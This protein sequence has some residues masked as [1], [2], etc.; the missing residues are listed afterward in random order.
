MAGLWAARA[1]IA[2]D[3]VRAR[4]LRRVFALPGTRLG[5]PRVG[6]RLHL[7]W[8][9]WWQAHLLD[10]LVDA[11]LREPEAE[12]DKVIAALVRGIHVRNFGAWTNRYYDDIAW[13]GLALQRA[14]GSERAL[15]AIEARLRSGWT[16]D[17]GGGIWWR[18]GDTFKNVPANGPAAI[19][20]A[21][22]GDHAWARTALDWM[23]RTLVDPETGLL[24]DGVRVG[25]EV[26][27]TIYTYCQG[28]FIGAAV[29][30]ST[31]DLAART[32][33]AVRRHV[34]TAHVLPGQGTGDGGLF[35]GI[36]ARYLAQSALRLP[37]AE[38][39]TARRLVFASADALWRHRVITADGP[40]FGTDWTTRSGQQRD[41]S[42]QLSA[43]MTL[44]AAALLARAGGASPNGV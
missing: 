37:T 21:R 16:D 7:R 29:E 13:L 19:F 42:V 39:D 12:R 33:R 43:W 10:C 4:F 36:L 28:V 27:E 31:P 20:L 35:A 9:Y 3:A 25:G 6:G 23:D 14:G 15:A 30:L 5:L 38:A 41:L 22:R 26:V 17:L 1:G 32:I 11:R 8:N 18:K 40:L 34:A 2:E 24:W 44:E